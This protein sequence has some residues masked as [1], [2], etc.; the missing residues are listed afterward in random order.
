MTKQ[1]ESSPETNAPVQQSEKPKKKFGRKRKEKRAAERSGWKE[2]LKNIQ[3]LLSDERNK[4]AIRKIKN[5]L[6]HMFRHVRVADA[7]GDM[8]YSLGSPDLTG[9][10][11]GLISLFPFAYGRRL[12]LTPD[13]LTE[14]IYARGEIR[15]KVSFQ[16]I[17]ALCAGLH[18]IFDKNV[19]RF[20]RKI[21]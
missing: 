5:E 21:F 10:A 18:I 12:Y 6:A 15:L 2:R 1:T 19:R 20:V 8:M 14:E 7:K 3:S 4:A 9:M 11:T 16:L 17:F 13:F